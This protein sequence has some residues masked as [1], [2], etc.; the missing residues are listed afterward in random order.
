MILLQEA[1]L[2]P[3]PPTVVIGGGNDMPPAIFILALLAILATAIIIFLPLMKAWARRI[4]GKHLDANE[5]RG[6]IDELRG[7]MQELEADRAR[8]VELEERLDF[9]ER[10]LAQGQPERRLERG[11][12]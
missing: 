10:L 2:P 5:I 7:R 9:A 4:E 11:G 12:A 8:F 3:L 1:P 6:E